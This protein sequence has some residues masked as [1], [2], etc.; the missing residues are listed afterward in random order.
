MGPSPST[1]AGRG[2]KE[3]QGGHHPVLATQ[4]EALRRPA[5]CSGTAQSLHKASL[6]RDDI[7]ILVASGPTGQSRMLEEGACQEETFLP[8]LPHA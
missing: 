3:V 5:D 1:P 4:L 6:G 7:Q 2:P 8:G